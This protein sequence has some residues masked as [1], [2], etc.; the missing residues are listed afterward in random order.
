MSEQSGWM[1]RLSKRSGV[2]VKNERVECMLTISEEDKFFICLC[3]KYTVIYF[4]F[5]LIIICRRCLKVNG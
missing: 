1:W 5:V 4:C 2:N 3:K